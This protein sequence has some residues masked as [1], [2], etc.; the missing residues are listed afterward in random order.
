[1]SE[2]YP[3]RSLCNV[4]EVTRSRYYSWRKARRN[5][6][7]TDRDS[8]IVALIQDLRRNKR[9]R[10]F[11]TRRLKRLLMDLAVVVSRKRLRRL[12]KQRGI[13]ALHKRAYRP[14]TT[15]SNHHL[16]IAPNRLARDFSPAA[17]NRVW[18]G[19]IT[20]LRRGGG[21]VY[22]AVV[23]DLYSRKIIGWS[24]SR[25]MQTSLVSDALKMALAMRGCPIGVIFHSD[26]GSQYASKKY[27]VVGGSSTDSQYVPKGRLLGQQS[28]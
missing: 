24:V 20:Y 14:K 28:G 17:A 8:E 21:F 7:R 6:D 18:A 22:L 27:R 13:K 10:S 4:M 15:D 26:R 11:G 3:I 25:R 9:M 23:M 16:A 5:T 1:M 12:M 2:Q 19:D